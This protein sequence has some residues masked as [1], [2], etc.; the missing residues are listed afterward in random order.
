MSK[1]SS[2]RRRAARAAVRAQGPGRVAV[3][4]HRHEMIP[5]PPFDAEH[6]PWQ[7]WW[8]PKP[9]GRGE[10]VRWDERVCE[11]VVQ[12]SEQDK[13]ERGEREGHTE[14]GL[15]VVKAKLT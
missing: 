3:G 8:N 11:F 13:V 2:M 7:F 5:A 12:L 6:P 15:H 9:N 10:W 1:K 4:G 14:S